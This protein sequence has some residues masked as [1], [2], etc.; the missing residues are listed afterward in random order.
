VLYNGRVITVDGAFSIAEAV[1][2]A[3]DR[4]V[5]V[6]TTAEVRAT[7]GPA[8]R[9]IDL[10]GRALIP[11]LMDNH[12]HSAGGGPGVDLSRARSLDDVYAAIRTRAQATMPG[13]AIVSNSDWH[14][15]QLKEQRLPL[16]DDLDRVAPNHPVILIRGGHEYIVNSAVLRRWGV[17][18]KATDPEGGR[19]TIAVGRIETEVGPRA[20]LTIGDTGCGMD[21]TVR[22]R[23]FETRPGVEIYAK[24]EGQNPTGSIKDRVA[25]A[26]IAAAEA[27]GEL[28]PGRRLLAAQL[29]GQRRSCLNH[30]MLPAAVATSAVPAAPGL[31]AARAPCAAVARRGA[32]A[33]APLLPHAAVPLLAA[34][35]LQTPAADAAVAGPETR[36]PGCLPHC[37]HRCCCWR[38][39]ASCCLPG[40]RQRRAR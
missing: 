28:T 23:A 26:M 2:I 14:E 29:A 4:I 6:G 21:E 30:S 36:A 17:D 27:S 40:R 13:E 1:G 10:R 35:P 8:A 20:R 19:L 39:P 31:L 16:R 38:L 32:P 3:G 34:G 7:A 5:A 11:G 18:E 25:L 24:L 12:L 9:Q 33:A 15:A 37:Y 22:L